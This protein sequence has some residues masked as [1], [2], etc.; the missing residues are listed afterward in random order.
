MSVIKVRK[1]I[2]CSNIKLK[3]EVVDVSIAEKYIQSYSATSGHDEYTW[4]SL[5]KDCLKK[6]TPPEK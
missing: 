2:S 6:L 1:C 3:D 4:A 5:C